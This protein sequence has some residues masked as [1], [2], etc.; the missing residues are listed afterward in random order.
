MPKRGG[1]V[2]RQER[3]GT[4]SRA[5]S[6]KRHSIVSFFAGCGGLDLGFLGDFVYRRKRL[7][8]LP[9]D[10]IR[11]YDFSPAAV[12]TYS[13]NIGP[14]AQIVDL[15][16]A[17][18]AE[19]PSAEILLGGFPCQ[20]FSVCGPRKGLQSDRG[21]L[22][23]CMVR[24]AAHHQPMLVVAENVANLLFI[25][26]GWDFRVIRNDFERIGYRC[27]WWKM[28]AAD[29]GVP[30]NRRRV[31]IIFVR[32]DLPSDPQA[33][34]AA[35]KGKHRT[36]EWAIGDLIGVADESVANQSQYF[37]AAAAGKGHGQGDETTP[38]DGPAYT[39]RANARSRIQF[40]YA[41][42]RRL[43]VRECARIQTFPDRFRFSFPPTESIRQ[44][45]NA[46]PP[47]LAHAV[48]ERLAAFLEGAACLRGKSGE[49]VV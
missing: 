12:A 36:S 28:N 20:E 23:K 14:H 35:F 27:V 39:I 22:Y 45:G 43:T 16:S 19:M 6:A 49:E 29:Y 38:R 15:A 2:R 25:N 13:T 11:A 21:R 32:D 1:A 17:E 41:L 44:I 37:K 9:F 46:V 42:P 7:R 30:Q 8:R 33:P 48:A 18:V 24:Y 10:I 26:D 47:V 3:R 4:T 5:S 40:H 34:I 31:F